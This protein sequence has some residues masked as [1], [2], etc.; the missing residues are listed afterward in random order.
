MTFKKHCLSK[1]P[2][3]TDPEIK[4]TLTAGE[5]FALHDSYLKT[6]VPSVEHIIEVVEEV[7]GQRGLKGARG[8]RQKS[9]AR[10]IAISLIHTLHKMSLES[11]GRIFGR[12][13]NSMMNSLSKASE[14]MSD[15]MFRE[16]YE[17]CKV[18]LYK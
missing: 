5:L 1:Y 10:H 2:L 3:W 6:K 14:L 12:K 4:V 13:H 17:N 8:D 18:N 7:T 16:K 15:D 11:L 9:D